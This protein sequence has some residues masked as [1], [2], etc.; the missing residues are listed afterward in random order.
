MFATRLR[1]AH[2]SSLLRFQTRPSSSSPSSSLPVSIFTPANSY[3]QSSSHF[4]TTNTLSNGKESQQRKGASDTY[5]GQKKPSWSS[6]L[7]LPQT[8]FP[9]KLKDP[10]RAEMRV[11]EKVTK[12]LYN[13]QREKNEGPVFVLH[14]GPPYANGN[15]HM[16]EL[17][18]FPL[19]SS[20]FFFA[21]GRIVG[22]PFKL[23]RHDARE[24][25]ST[26]AHIRY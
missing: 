4:S 18:S 19:A 1:S 24:R 2:G 20:S 5:L 17:S 13:T 22:S 8:T 23:L 25:W 26:C 11:R 15:L 6:T 21:F 3:A 10:V 9:M 16:G 14:D 7:L 12:D